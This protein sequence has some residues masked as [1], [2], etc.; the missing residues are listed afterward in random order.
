MLQNQRFMT[1]STLMTKY[2]YIFGK[3]V[4]GFLLNYS[5]YLD[6]AGGTEETYYFAWVCMGGYYNLTIGI[7][8][9][10]LKFKNLIARKTR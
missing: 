1:I 3:H 10:T 6:L 9:H 7:F 8:L 2:F 4:I 5:M